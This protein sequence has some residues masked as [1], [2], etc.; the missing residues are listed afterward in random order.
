MQAKNRLLCWGY[1]RTGAR[2]ADPCEPEV[3]SGLFFVLGIQKATPAAPAKVGIMTRNF[4]QNSVESWNHG[5]GQW[6]HEPGTEA[7][8][9]QHGMKS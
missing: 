9:R 6:R 3:C 7:R 5:P 1:K 2:G 8:G 4:C